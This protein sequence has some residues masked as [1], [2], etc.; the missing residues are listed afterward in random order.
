[1]ELVIVDIAGRIVK[2]LGQLRSDRGSSDVGWDGTDVDSER[3][4]PGVYFA[5]VI[6]EGWRSAKKLVILTQ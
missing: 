3:V 6:G 4:A 2:S 1:M 5:Q